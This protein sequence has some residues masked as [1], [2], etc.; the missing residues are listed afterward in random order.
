MDRRQALV[1]VAFGLGRALRADVARAEAA[2]RCYAAGARIDEDVFVQDTEQR[3][4]PLLSLLK[5]PVNVLVIL[6]GAEHGAVPRLWCGDSQRELP[7]LKRLRA[8]F[9]GRGVAYVAVA[10]TP[11]YAEKNHGYVDGTFLKTPESHPTYLAAVA[12][13]V[14]ETEKL[15]ER[16]ELAAF[17]AVYY[18]PRF[19][20]LDNPRQG[21]HVP[22]YGPV[23]PW[24]GRFKPCEDAQRH[25][26]PV[27]WLIGMDGTVLAAPFW[28]NVY[29][30]PDKKVRYEIE[31]V[32]RALE[33]ALSR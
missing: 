21:R 14:A 22:E 33:E 7:M 17:D 23:F 15:R 2:C 1:G 4:I 8:R 3:A 5:R 19:R 16:G 10:V 31:D 18:D 11:A 27:L 32:A 26:T 29:A 13:F 30:E 12:Q 28:G 25:G 24:Q 20:L 6:G 9:A